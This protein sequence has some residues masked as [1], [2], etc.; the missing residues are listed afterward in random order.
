MLRILLELEPDKNIRIDTQKQPE[1]ENGVCLEAILE[2]TPLVR[3][4]TL[5]CR[6]TRSESWT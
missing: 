4:V 1:Q 6:N 5:L 2:T 3:A